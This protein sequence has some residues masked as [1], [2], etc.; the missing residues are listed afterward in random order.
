MSSD[1]G[2]PLTPA[3][4]CGPRTDAAA[5]PSAH[6]AAC[7][8]GCLLVTRGSSSARAAVSGSITWGWTTVVPLGPTPGG[9]AAC[10]RQATVGSAGPTTPIAAPLHGWCVHRRALAAT[11]ADAR[12]GG[13]P[14]GLLSAVA[15]LSGGP[16]AAVRPGAAPR[17]AG[18]ATGGVGLTDIILRATGRRLLFRK[19]TSMF[20]GLKMGPW[21]ARLGFAPLW[22]AHTDDTRWLPGQQVSI[23]TTKALAP[24]VPCAGLS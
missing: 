17:V 12:R 10:P 2:V 14:F 19:R 23:L 16:L 11:K 6:A 21:K 15:T 9:T 7:H 24:T 5:A 1:D 8:G 22:G 18:A 4:R 13:S 3:G 20:K